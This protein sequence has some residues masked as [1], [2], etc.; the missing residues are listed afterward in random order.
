MSDVF[1][2]GGSI[3]DG[4]RVRGRFIRVEKAA[5]S[6]AGVFEM[7]TIHCTCKSDSQ[8]QVSHGKFS[9]KNLALLALGAA[10]RGAGGPRSDP[11]VGLVGWPFELS[12]RL[13]HA[14]RTL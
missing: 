14:C 12:L 6:T 2:D 3:F 13:M 8:V 4:F 7:C 10:W 1:F 11:F 9:W 5:E